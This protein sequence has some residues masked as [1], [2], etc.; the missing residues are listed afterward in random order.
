M[1]ATTN[2]SGARS[3]LHWVPAASGLVLG[4]IAA[5]ALLSSVSTGV[6]HLTRVPREFIDNY[7]FN[8]PDTSFAWAFALAVMAG[9]LA[10]RK[11]IAWWV[12]VANLLL[13]VG[14]DIAG[15]TGTAG[16]RFEDVG[17]FL[18]LTLHIAALV[19]LVL[20]YNEFWAKV[21]RGAVFKA[22]AVLVAVN[23]VGILLAW[24]LLELFPGS[25]QRDYRLPYA[26]NRVSGFAVATPDLFVG[27]PHV[28]LNALFG[29]FG[30][31]A[32][33]A[34]AV[35]LFQSQRAEN[36]LTGEDESAI[37][38]L[39]E[40]WGKNDSLG[41]FATRR[42]KSVIFAPS[43]RAA[44]TYRVEIGVCLASGDQAVPRLR[45]GTRGDGSQ[46]DRRAG[47]PGGRFERTAT[48]R[49]GDSLSRQVPAV[50][51]GYEGCAPGG[52]PGPAGRANGADAPPP[53][54]VRRGNGPGHQTRG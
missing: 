21:R 20:A 50:R 43:G 5:A 28:F 52:H 24:G 26:I 41:Y 10:A 30:A 18:G 12:L 47:L 29:L 25:L 1:T 40:A 7:L 3:R 9:A 22:V 2:R 13:A 4:T 48:R 37:R 49:R 17:E 11:R 15:L 38:G 45:V 14:F 39:L 34:A 27:K 46:F 32:L 51:G 8:F 44:V 54:A 31:I 42:D 19:L 23:V 36:A 53:R 16:T 35:V 33:M 6:R